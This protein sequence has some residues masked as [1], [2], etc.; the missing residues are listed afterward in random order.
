ME[1]VIEQL[2]TTGNVLE[3]HRF[4]QHSVFIGRAFNS[5]VLLT[6]EHVDA[7]HARLSFDEEGR[8]WIEDLGS[9]NGIRR[10]R[11]K[12]RVEREAVESGEVFLIGR[13]RVRI[14]LG[15][16]PVPEAV[17]IRFSEVFLLWLGKPQVLVGMAAAYILTLVG[18]TYFTTIGEFRWTLVIEQ[19]LG[20]IIGF[21]L[22]AVGVYF[23]S[24]LFRRGG[25]FLAHLSI[26]IALFFVSGLLAL[27]MDLA[28]FN[29]SDRWYGVIDGLDSVRKYLLLFVYLWSI[30]YLAFHLSLARRTWISAVVVAVIFGVQH[31]PDDPA[32]DFLSAETYPLR[33]TML[34]PQ[35]LLRAPAGSGSMQQRRAD[36]FERVEQARTE[37][38]AERDS[39]A[40]ESEGLPEPE[41][42]PGPPPEPGPQPEPLPPPDEQD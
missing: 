2:G 7:R 29:A 22:L 4:D 40:A 3:R 8:L 41:P 37:A 38:L 25:N 32:M 15:E 35:F 12:A 11:H 30:L 14:L 5:D 28:V 9:V 39:A 31:L 42:E 26:L 13:T 33:Q 10:P 36:L 17:R 6:D 24:I 34:P 20:E 16:H 18:I 19:N 27:A 21:I 1:V 23:L